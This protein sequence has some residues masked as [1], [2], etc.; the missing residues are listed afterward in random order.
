MAFD[1]LRKLGNFARIEKA[2]EGPLLIPTAMAATSVYLYLNQFV[3]KQVVRLAQ[4]QGVPFPNVTWDKVN[5]TAVREWHSI[6][7]SFNDLQS[8]RPMGY[9]LDL[10][11]LYLAAGSAI[12]IGVGLAAI[13]H[14]FLKK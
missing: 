1:S 14:L 6:A 10:N 11:P 9:E 5:E 13:N 12:V 7:Q 3:Q 4:S 2:L 8:L